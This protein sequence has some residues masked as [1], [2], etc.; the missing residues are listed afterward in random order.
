MSKPNAS[1]RSSELALDERILGPAE[2]VAIGVRDV[3]VRLESGMV[4]AAVVAL[5]TRYEARVGDEVLVISQGG[6]SWIIGVISGSGSTVLSFDGDVE[7][8]SNDGTVRVSGA[9]GVEIDG[10][11]IDLRSST[12]SI[13]AEA[14]VER[15]A[16][17]TQRVR[18]LMSIHV[19][20]KHEIVDGSSTSQAKSST[21]L[22][23]EDVKIN[24]RTVHLG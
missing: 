17:F 19:G 14:L 6:R 21:L 1:L 11:R 8:R 15:V 18:D 20:K 12:L 3:E 7:L 16:S 2:V 4:V 22:T 9:R 5:A 23:Q 24:G 10:P 13:A